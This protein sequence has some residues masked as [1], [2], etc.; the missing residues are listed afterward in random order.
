[1][2]SLR[3]L[4]FL[5]CLWPARLHAQTQPTHAALTY[6]T[7]GGRALQLDLYRP[8]SLVAPAPLV[9]WVHGGGWSGGSRFPAQSAAE[10]NARGIAVASISY[11]LTSQAGQFGDQQVSFPAQI[12]DVKA[13]LR[14]LRANAAGYG[15]HA[16]RIGAWGS[17][18]GGHLVALLGTSGDVGLIEGAVGLADGHSSRVQAVVD[19]YGPTDIVQFV[20]DGGAAAN[21]AFSSAGSTLLGFTAADQGIGVLRAQS[22]N[23]ANPYPLYRELARQLNPVTWVDAADPPFLI[24][25]GTADATVPF[26]QSRRLRDALQAAGRS[27]QMIEVAGGGHGGF[28]AAVQDQARDF[29]VAQL[30]APVPIGDPAA[31][32]GSWYD[33]NKDGEGFTLQWQ[34]D[35]RLLAY[36]YG[37][38]DDRSNLNLV[39]LVAAT[40]RYGEALRIE[41]VRF[42]GGRY[43]DY[44]PAL[45]QRAA[46]G[47]VDLTFTDCDHA[48]ARLEGSDGVQTLSLVRV[49]RVGALR[50]D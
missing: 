25:H 50:C 45:V 11:R 26:G 3:F 43:S 30:T 15:L 31:L 34:P 14:W 42:S 49:A 5:A 36:F 9:L 32:S 33:P 47:R 1:M 37:Y 19:Y 4:V 24:V 17:S 39:G 22:A 46:W 12:H 7:V 10:L 27:V 20:P 48:S 8:T 13:A 28:P 40:P 29:L 16:G 41:L 2:T 35:G 18:A 6:A 23:S 44:D 38:R 21:D